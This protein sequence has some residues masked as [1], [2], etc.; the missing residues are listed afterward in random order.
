MKRFTLGTIL[1]AA[2]LGVTAQAQVITNYGQSTY[3][4][5]NLSGDNITYGG[6]NGTWDGYTGSGIVPTAYVAQTFMTPGAITDTVNL[7]A[8]NNQLIDLSGHTATFSAAIYAWTPSGAAGTGLNSGPGNTLNGSIVNGSYVAG[9]NSTFDVTT[10]SFGPYGN[11]FS[12]A[13]GIALMGG[14]IYA[15]VIQR[16]DLAGGTAQYGMDSTATV[17]GAYAGGSLYSSAAGTNFARI[18]APG[19]RDLAFWVSFQAETLSPVPEPAV[20]GAIIGGVFVAGLLIWRR[21]GRKSE[22]QVPTSV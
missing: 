12:N 8:Y 9:T 2:L 3:G 20:N 19:Y 5:S 13:G 18:G 1:F 14:T 15:L 7:Y 22:N 16:T 17:D 6:W 10:P 21:Y 11:N 4:P